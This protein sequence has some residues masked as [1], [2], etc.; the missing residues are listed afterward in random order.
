MYLNTVQIITQSRPNGYLI[1]SSTYMYLN[2]VQI[3]TQSRRNG[4]LIYSSTY[5][6][7]YFY[8]C[9]HVHVIT[10][11]YYSTY[12]GDSINIATIEFD[13]RSPLDTCPDKMTMRRLMAS[14]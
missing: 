5:M 12:R 14:T 8:N 3:I 1:Y 2:T 4:Y 6:Y 9:R 10:C 11:M 7:I 13:D